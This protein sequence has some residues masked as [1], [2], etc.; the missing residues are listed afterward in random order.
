MGTPNH[1]R[2]ALI[3]LVALVAAACTTGNAPSTTL[4]ALTTSATTPA[5]ATSTTTTAVTTSTTT[6][7]LSSPTWYRV[8]PD[9]AVLGGAS[10]QLMFGVTVGGPGLVA[11]GNDVSGGDSD[12]AVWNSPDGI[13]WARVPHDETVLGG[14]GIQLMHS[15]TAGGPGLVAVGWDESGGDSDAAVWTSPDGIIWSRVP[16]D[17]TVLGGTGD[18]AMENV[19]A[20][21]PGLVAVGREGPGGDLNAAVWTSPDGIIWSRVP[22]DEAVFGGEG[23]QVMWGVTAAGPGLVAVG[24]EFSGDDDDAAVWTSSDGITWSRVPDDDGVLGGEGIQVMEGV[25]AGGPGLVAVGWDESGGD[26]NAAVWTSP[27]GIIWS[28]VPHHEA[29]LGGA[30]DQQMLSVTTAGPGLVGAGFDASDDDWDAAVWTSSDGITWSR[31]PDDEAV[32][33]GDGTQVML[34]VTAVGP[35]LAAVGFDA[36]GG[37]GDAGVWLATSTDSTGDA[38]ASAMMVMV[39][40]SADLGTVYSDFVE[41]PGQRTGITY[42]TYFF[43][44]RYLHPQSDQVPLG[45][46]TQVGVYEDAAKASQAVQ[47][48]L[49]NPAQA[50]LRMLENLPVDLAG[51]LLLASDPDAVP[52][53]FDVGSFGDSSGGAYHTAEALGDPGSSVHSGAFFTVVAVFHRG[54]VVAI[55]VAIGQDLQLAQ[56]EVTRLAGIMDERIQKAG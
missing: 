8:P 51:G 38:A 9:E 3:L 12:A 14:A 50:L 10:D 29:V 26:L 4:P 55:V 48:E 36:R 39:A 7:P 24:S 37:D 13:A 31:V 45:V 30:G 41:I 22:D 33:G 6:A 25:T 19:T 42:G 2:V 5:V 53:E 20:G 18:Q 46:F 35:G 47:T 56:Q 34:S 17:E 32:F 21:G 54:P 40:G 1:I 44:E 11:V 15:V 28:R 43:P 16:H 23:I 52:G 27:D 49:E